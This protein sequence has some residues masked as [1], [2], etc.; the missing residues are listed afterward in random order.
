MFET[1]SPLTEFYSSIQLVTLEKEYG[2][3]SMLTQHL[4]L[5]KGKIKGTVEDSNVG[6]LTSSIG[7][8]NLQLHIE[9]FLS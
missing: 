8:P 4:I 3:I 1:G 2:V 5:I 6:K 9:K 7:P